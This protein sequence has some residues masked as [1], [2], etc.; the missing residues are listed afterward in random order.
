M[1]QMFYSDVRLLCCDKEL[2]FE[3]TEIE[4]KLR[5]KCECCGKIISA[6][7]VQMFDPW[8]QLHHQKW[9]FYGGY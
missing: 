7:K 1:S 8:E 5:A 9:Y 4:Y 2:K 3:H 6:I